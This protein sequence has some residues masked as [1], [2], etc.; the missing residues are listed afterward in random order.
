MPNIK[1]FLLLGLTI[2]GIPPILAN[3]AKAKFDVDHFK[4]LRSPNFL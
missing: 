1:Q 2:Q 4:E 3:I